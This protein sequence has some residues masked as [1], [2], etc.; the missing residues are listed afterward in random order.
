MHHETDT[1][2][3]WICRGTLILEK[4]LVNI[5]FATAFLLLSDFLF[6]FTLILMNNELSGLQRKFFLGSGIFTPESPNQS[7]HQEPTKVFA[8][9]CTFDPVGLGFTLFY[10]KWTKEVCRTYR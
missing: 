10:L 6:C 9:L 3:G 1:T 2:S 8:A 4:V 5:D 7:Q